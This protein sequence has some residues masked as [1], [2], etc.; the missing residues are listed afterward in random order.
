LAY[1]H[2]EAPFCTLIQSNASQAHRWGRPRFLYA[3][4]CFP[5]FVVALRCASANPCWRSARRAEQFCPA[6][7]L[8]VDSPWNEGQCHFKCV[9]PLAVAP[10]NGFKASSTV[11]KGGEAATI[12]R[13]RT[14][15]PSS[16]LHRLCLW[17]GLPYPIAHF[18]A[19][20][21]I[22]DNG[23]AAVVA[24]DIGFTAKGDKSGYFRR[25]WIDCDQRACH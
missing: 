1:L 2:T 23:Q 7:G 21:Y 20:G 15:T 12:R 6:T 5:L 10:G 18:N 13:P 25:V 8:H 22:D 19:F 24:D 11:A 4:T 14:S 9:Q 3:I 17:F 16:H